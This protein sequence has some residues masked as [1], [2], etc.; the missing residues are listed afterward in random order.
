LYRNATIRKPPKIATFF[1][2]WRVQFINPN[3]AFLGMADLTY[4]RLLDVIGVVRSSK[5]AFF[6][7]RVIAP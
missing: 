6:A 5:A 2:S 1:V 4:P 7:P 3:N